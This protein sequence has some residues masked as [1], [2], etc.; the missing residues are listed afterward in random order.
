MRGDLL[1][2]AWRGS[3]IGGRYRVGGAGKKERRDQSRAFGGSEGE[4]REGKGGKEDAEG[5]NIRRRS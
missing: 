1:G 2:L 5:F 3:G 4:G